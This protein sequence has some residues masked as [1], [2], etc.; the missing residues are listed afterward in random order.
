MIVLSLEPVN[1]HR[2]QSL[3]LQTQEGEISQECILKSPAYNS[4]NQLNWDF[5]GGPVAKTLHSQSRE[6]GFNPWSGN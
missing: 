2:R 3:G 6:S 4:Q 5:P 1:F